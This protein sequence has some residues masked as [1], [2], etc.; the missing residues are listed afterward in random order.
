MGNLSASLAGNFVIINLGSGG[1]FDYDLTSDFR[2]SITLVELDAQTG[3]TIR[4]EYFKRHNVTAFVAGK[5]GTRIFTVH[6][7]PYCSSLNTVNPELIKK[8]G[9]DEHY[10]IMLGQEVECTTLSS[11]LDSLS[12]TSVDFLKTDLEGEDL[13]VVKSIGD[14]VQDCVAVQMELHI[15]PYFEVK[16]NIYD[17]VEYLSNFGFELCCLRPE[18]WKMKTK[19]AHLHR[20]GRIVWADCLFLK[21]LPNNPE[22]LSVAKQIV[23]LSMLQRRGYAEYLAETYNNILPKEWEFEIASLTAPYGL[24]RKLKQHIYYPVVG[25]IRR[26]TSRTK[27]TKFNYEHVAER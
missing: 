26:L 21:K 14:K 25:L 22:P 16:P 12:I 4:A 20:D 3:A 7:Y 13:S 17:A 9:L 24:E 15:E 11:V 5:A 10:K 19:N 1:D 6:K 2:R 23:I 27:P 18:F 8:Y